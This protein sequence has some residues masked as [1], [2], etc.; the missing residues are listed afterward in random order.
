MKA[1]SRISRSEFPALL[2]GRTV[3]G[4][5]LE[6]KYAPFPGRISYAMVVSAKVA[7]SAADRNRLRRRGRAILQKLQ[8]TVEPGW[9]IAL[10]FKKGAPKLSFAELE[11]EIRSLL[12]KT[13]FFHS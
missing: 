12:L 1:S 10:F 9:G 13:S 4:E 3:R 7:P 6:L 2:A 11:V 8:K 5:H